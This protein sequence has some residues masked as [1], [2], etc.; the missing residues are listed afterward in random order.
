MLAGEAD[1]DGIRRALTAELAV[2]RGE[3]DALRGETPAVTTMEE[4][5]DGTILWWPPC[6][7]WDAYALFRDDAEARAV[8]APGPWLTPGLSDVPGLTWVQVVKQ[9]ERADPD[10]GGADSMSRAVRLYRADDPAIA[11]LSTE[12]TP[13]V[14]AAVGVAHVGGLA[15]LR[16]RDGFVSMYPVDAEEIAAKLIRAARAVRDV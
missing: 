10:G 13:I 7:D 14:A 11:V 2:L 8:G 9:V 16:V 6:Y 1:R 5:P 12:D 3:A 15:T 4:P